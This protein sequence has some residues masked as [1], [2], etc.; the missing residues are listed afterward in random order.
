[1]SE[2]IS[3]KQLETISR[4]ELNDTGLFQIM[5][6]VFG[7]STYQVFTAAWIHNK[8]CAYTNHIDMAFHE[9]VVMG[10]APNHIREYAVKCLTGKAVLLIGDNGDE[11]ILLA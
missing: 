11:G 8:G 1:M 6:E 9:F 7:L 4:S 5:F 10:R 3:S 2:W